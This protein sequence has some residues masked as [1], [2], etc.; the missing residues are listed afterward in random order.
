MFLRQRG[1]QSAAG[2]A[3]PAERGQQSAPSRARPAERAQQSAASRAR[4]AERGRQ[5]AQQSAPS[6]ARPA[7]RA[8]QS[9][10]RTGLWAAIRA[11]R[12][13]RPHLPA[14]FPQTRRA[15]QL[16]KDREYSKLPP[17]SARPLDSFFR[18]SHILD[19]LFQ[20]A[21]VLVSTIGVALQEPARQSA[22]TIGVPV[23]AS[24]VAMNKYSMLGKAKHFCY[25][26]SARKGRWLR[27][28]KVPAAWP[29]AA[30]ETVIP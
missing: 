14:R 12:P 21:D 27:K 3:R 19:S 18:D 1:R 7:E 6:R 29:K 22:A 24:R 23:T 28:A 10:A 5:S 16:R 30:Q 20:S 17:F 8:Q 25:S 26:S 11:T 15:G 2:R 4:P 9:A 13:P